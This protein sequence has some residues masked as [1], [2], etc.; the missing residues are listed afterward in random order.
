[1]M[2]YIDHVYVRNTIPFPHREVIWNYLNSY[3]IRFQLK[4]HI[5]FN[6]LVTN[7]Q[8]I[9]SGKWKVVV[10]D[11]PNNKSVSNIFDAIIV[12]NGHN[13]VPN[14][15]VFEGIDDFTGKILHSHDFRNADS[16]SGKKLITFST[17]NIFRN[18]FRRKCSGNWKWL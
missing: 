8:P 4:K 3:A 13:S 15:P 17:R 9:E 6:H 10:K 14:I 7:V 12:C 5:Q 1:M 11:L 2:E 16:Y 18:F